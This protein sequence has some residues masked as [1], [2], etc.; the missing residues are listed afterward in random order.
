MRV[1]TDP[2]D[3]SWRQPGK[4]SEETI[5]I[6]R[7][8]TLTL[9][10]HSWLTEETALLCY[11]GSKVCRTGARVGGRG[12]GQARTKEM[13]KKRE[14]ISLLILKKLNR[15]CHRE[16]MIPQTFPKMGQKGCSSSVPTQVS[17]GMEET[18]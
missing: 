17:M 10:L 8:W 12:L 11:C 13:Q 4:M 2:G 16:A 3:R 14:T 9:R 15:T 7:P 6:T 5:L 1:V 18:W